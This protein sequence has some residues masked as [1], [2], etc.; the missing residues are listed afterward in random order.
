M[1]P[2]RDPTAGLFSGLI[3][4]GTVKIWCTKQ[5]GP[6]RYVHKL[7]ATRYQIIVNETLVIPPNPAEGLKFFIEIA[8]WNSYTMAVPYLSNLITTVK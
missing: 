5:S 7:I 2:G 8:H 6:F 1:D 4:V 3:V